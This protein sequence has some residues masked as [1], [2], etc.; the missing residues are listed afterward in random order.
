MNSAAT[1]PIRSDSEFHH[2]PTYRIRAVSSGQHPDATP[3]GMEKEGGGDPVKSE[4]PCSGRLGV[5]SARWLAVRTVR[6]HACGQ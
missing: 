2:E 6:A 4:G 1:G 5:V 3:T